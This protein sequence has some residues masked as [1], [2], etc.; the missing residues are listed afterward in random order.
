MSLLDT[1]ARTGGTAYAHAPAPTVPPP[2][3]LILFLV[4]ITGVRLWL[5]GALPLTEDEAYYRLWAAALQFGYYDHPPMIAWWI[6]A[7][8]SIAGDNALGVRLFPALSCTLVSFIIFDLTQRLG[9]E[10]KTAVR[11]AVWYNATLIVGLGGFLATPDAAAVLFWTLALWCLTKVAETETGGA[12]AAR[13]WIAAGVAAGLATISKYSA[14]FLAPGVLIWLA[15]RPTGLAPLRKPWP[16]I[17]AAV[18]A[19]IFATNLVWNAEH[20]WVSFVKQFGRVAA[21]HF[22]PKHFLE[23]L[24]SELGLLNPIIT[25]FAALGVAAYWR[26]PKPAERPDM[27]LLLATSL[28]F[29]VYLVIHSFHDRVQAHWPAPL[30]PG[31]AIIAAVAA[32]QAAPGGRLALLRRAAAPFGLIL[33]AVVMIHLVAPFTDIKGLRDPTDIIRGWSPFA[34]QVRALRLAQHAGWV[35]TMSYGTA[36]QLDFE[37]EGGP[38]VQLMDRDRYTPADGSWRADLKQPGLIVDIARRVGDMAALPYCFG[39]VRPLGDIQRGPTPYAVFLVANPKRDVLGHGC[40]ASKL[41]LHKESLQR[42]EDGS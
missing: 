10:V 3:S 7:G 40:W 18:A 4:V 29:A 5:A 31:L 19:A 11:A 27:S 15:M 39:V 34:A 28:P 22:E 16:W 9:A 37:R 36:A 24:A 33:S 30:Y 21:S 41:Q 25:W 38:V 6:R 20:H 17:A 32:D 1:D 8:M 2:R 14:L 12:G 23:F 35:G 26:K 42:E 13:W